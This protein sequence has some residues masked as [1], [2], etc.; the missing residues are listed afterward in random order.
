MASEIHS[1][2]AEVN[3]LLNLMVNSIYS[4]KEVFLRELI[5]NASDALDKLG[6]SEVTNHELES[7]SK[8]KSI[9]VRGIPDKKLLV[10]EDNGM[11]MTKEEL[12][13]NLGTIANSGTKKFLEQLTD[14]QKK[15]SNLIGQFGV[16]FYSAFMVSDKITVESFSA[17]DKKAFKWESSCDG[18]YSIEPSHKK[19]RGTTITLHLKEDAKEFSEEFRLR[20]I[21]KKYSDYVTYPIFLRVKETITEDDKEE[22]SDKENQTKSKADDSKESK[23]KS[24]ESKKDI[25]QKVIEKDERVNKSTPVWARSKKDNKKEDY[26]EL[27]K[28]LSFD[29]QEPLLWEHISL[30]G[31]VPFTAL[32]YIPSAA[33]FDLYTR[34]SHGLHL[35]T[36]RVCISEKCKELLPEYLRFA[37]G[38]VETDEIPLNISR[39]ILQHNTKLPIIKKQIVKK[40]LAALKKLLEKDKAA[41]TKFYTT[42]GAVL[43]E[44]FHYDTEQ[45][46]TLAE[47]ALFQSSKT[48][49]DEWV[50]LK[51]YIERKQ[52]GQKDIFFITGPSYEAVV[53]SPH[54]EALKSKNVEVLFMT[55]PID[56]WLVMNYTKHQDMAFKSV[57]KGDID[58]STVKNSE[59]KTNDKKDELPA[60]D[61]AKLMEVFRKR[62]GDLIKDVKISKRLTDSS[63]CLVDDESGISSNMAKIL[64][65][66]NPD[67]MKDNKKILEINPSHPVMKNLAQ[68]QKAGGNDASLNDWVEMLYE[69]A[70]ISEG[71]QL[72]DPGAFAKRLSGLMEKASKASLGQQ[73]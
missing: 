69:S 56:E 11:G 9:Y 10:I 42:F 60:E 52:E 28:Q 2:E 14:A 1:F 18:K 54:L 72:K 51:D 12:I 27:Y 29:W 37:S 22:K 48:G 38:V 31:R 57:N 47:L 71:N 55:D 44:G 15:D 17:K 20:Q 41:Y 67:A 68:M 8:E 45:H 3:Q 65:A 66:T 61:M 62:L 58:L 4:N 6:F 46:S 25:K 5:S 59:E 30:E 50:S 49:K 34:E 63:C 73:P 7:S 21:I 40:L 64:Q 32:V 70:I 39:E 53:H 26:I 36:K 16:G 19:D 24:S 33:P 13:K 35:Y 43:K 23:T